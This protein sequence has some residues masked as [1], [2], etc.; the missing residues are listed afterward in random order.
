M[1]DYSARMLN[2]EFKRLGFAMF[3]FFAWHMGNGMLHVPNMLQNPRM[4]TLM[5]SIEGMANDQFSPYQGLPPSQIPRALSYAVATPFT[6]HDGY[7]R[8]LMPEL[9]HEPYKRLMENWMTNPLNPFH[10]GAE[11]FR[12][13][14]G[15]TRFANALYRATNITLRKRMEHESAWDT[16]LG[17]E[18]R[19]GYAEDLMWGLAP[20]REGVRIMLE[21]LEDPNA[22]NDSAFIAMSMLMR[23]ESFDE[24]GK[25]KHDESWKGVIPRQLGY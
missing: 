6:D 23:N 24:K 11:N 18:A 22:W 1:I 5:A 13:V 3:P 21:S 8:W 20:Y 7:Q 12:F 10:I 14:V 9:P 4:Y 2:P 15:R 16:M 25:M 17:S 19:Q